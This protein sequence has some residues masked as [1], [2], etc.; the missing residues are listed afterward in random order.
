MLVI[1]SGDQLPNPVAVLIGGR[2][3]HRSDST[4]SKEAIGARSQMGVDIGAGGV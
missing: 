1:N 4:P 3:P 2:N